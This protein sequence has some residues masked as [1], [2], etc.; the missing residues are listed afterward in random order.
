MDKIIDDTRAIKRIT[1]EGEDSFYEVG[2]TVGKIVP[3]EE[4]GEMAAITWFAIYSRENKPY[5][6][7]II[8]RV[9]SKF[10]DSVCYQ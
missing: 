8:A 7:S 3:Y 9:N 6:I 1:L 4:N 5:P 2:S 10:V